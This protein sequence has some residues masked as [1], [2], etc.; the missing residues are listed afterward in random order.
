MRRLICVGSP[1]WRPQIND[2]ISSNPN[3]CGGE[4]CIKRTRIPVRQLVLM[5][6]NSDSIE[7]LLDDDPTLTR[8]DVLAAPAFADGPSR[9]HT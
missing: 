9:K 4:P 1:V 6:R 7:R 2:R 5:L 3:V 8:E